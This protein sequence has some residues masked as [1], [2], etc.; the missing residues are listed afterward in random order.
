MDVIPIISCNLTFRRTIKLSVTDVPAI[1]THLRALSNDTTAAPAVLDR[2]T[3]GVRRCIYE[4]AGIPN[5]QIIPPG[6]RKS[7]FAGISRSHLKDIRQR[8]FEVL[9]DVASP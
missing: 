5:M 8:A 1:Y 2:S 3:T 6:L 9:E 4:S 7:S